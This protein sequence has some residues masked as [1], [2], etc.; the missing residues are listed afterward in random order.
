MKKR[1][2]TILLALAL[3]IALIPAAV[4]AEPERGTVRLE[5][6]INPQYEDARNFYE[7]LA[8][9]KRNGKWGF[10]DE[11]NRTVIPFEY[12]YALLF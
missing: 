12:D 7:G 1:I 11:D 2:I 9:V 5:R 10:I 4:A 6:I 3:F 8:A